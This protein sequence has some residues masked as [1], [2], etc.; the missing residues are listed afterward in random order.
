MNSR[1]TWNIRSGE[2]WHISLL[3]KRP[4]TN[5]GR[6]LWLFWKKS[7]SRRT[8]QYKW[9]LLSFPQ[10]KQLLY[11][12][13]LF[14]LLKIRLA[15]TDIERNSVKSQRNSAARRIVHLSVERS[16][17]FNCKNLV[18]INIINIGNVEERFIGLTPTQ[19]FTALTWLKLGGGSLHIYT[20]IFASVVWPTRR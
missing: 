20:Y 12:V 14:P 17:S 15:T 1:S 9:P 3:F 2:T 8:S 13:I 6:R 11:R 10:L 16:N 4:R 7:A 19:R 18:I 5:T